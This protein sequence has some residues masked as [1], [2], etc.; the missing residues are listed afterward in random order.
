MSPRKQGGLN[1]T[2]LSVSVILMLGSRDAGTVVQVYE[3][4]EQLK[5]QTFWLNE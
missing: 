4:V 1:P 2:V 3:K 5:S